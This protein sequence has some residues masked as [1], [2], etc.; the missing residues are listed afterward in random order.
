MT[1]AQAVQA[2]ATNARVRCEAG[3]DSESG[4]ISELIDETTAIVA[5][6]QGIKTPH[7]IADLDLE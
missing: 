1:K 5:W 2:I 7:P 6:D 3:E 4:Y